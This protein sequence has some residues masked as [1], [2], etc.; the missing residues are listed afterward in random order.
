MMVAYENDEL[1]S[2]SELAK[3]FGSYLAKIKDHSVEKLAVLKNNRIEAVVVSKE[4]YEKMQE[5]LKLQEAEAF[6]ED[7]FRALDEAEAI[8][9]GKKKAHPIDTL[10]DAL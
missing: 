1:V 5:A 3:K 8:K 7:V 4:E 6:R 2:S 10:W 9:N